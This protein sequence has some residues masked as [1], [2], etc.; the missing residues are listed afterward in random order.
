MALISFSLLY[1]KEESARCLSSLYRVVLYFLVC[2]L[3]PMW[4]A[5]MLVMQSTVSIRRMHL[6][7]SVKISQ[8]KH[9]RYNKR[10][11]I[12]TQDNTKQVRRR[13]RYS[14]QFKA[15]LVA[16]YLAGGVSLASLAISHDINP[17]ILHRW[18]REHKRQGYPSG[19]HPQEELGPQG[20]L[21][22]GVFTGWIR[23][24]ANKGL[25]CSKIIPTLLL[26]I[27]FVKC[28]Y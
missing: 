17:N 11:L 24:N 19:K 3:A 14:A 16:E 27:T 5:L 2:L 26:S 6:F 7:S 1:V 22:Q 13:R 12:M 10:V 23:L 4:S 21:G 15:E 20:G 9:P 18:V 28:Y 25:W 8:A